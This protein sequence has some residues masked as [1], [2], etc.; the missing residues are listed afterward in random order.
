VP[1]AGVPCPIQ[2]AYNKAGSIVLP[3]GAPFDG[4]EMLIELA[5]G[6]VQARWAD[7]EVQQTQ[8]G[9]EHY[10]FC[11]VCLDDSYGQQELDSAKRWMPLPPPAEG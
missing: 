5:E 1:T 8:D 9:P 3:P 4:K 6:W 11:W 2:Y 10:G 7:T